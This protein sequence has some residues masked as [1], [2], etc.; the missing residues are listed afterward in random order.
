MSSNKYLSVFQLTAFSGLDNIQTIAFDRK[1]YN[2]SGIEHP[3]I[4]VTFPKLSS[5][6]L[7]SFADQENPFNIYNPLLIYL[8]LH[9]YGM[10]LSFP[11]ADLRGGGV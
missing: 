1:S 8:S 6:R 7:A 4:K 3:D 9:T 11:G 2:C 5:F 10:R